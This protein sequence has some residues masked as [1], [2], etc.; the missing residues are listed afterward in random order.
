MGD[1]KEHAG[2]VYRLLMPTYLRGVMKDKGEVEQGVEVSG[3]DFVLVRLPVLT[4]GD[5]TGAVKVAE[6][7]ET[8][9]SITRADLAAFL[10]EQL[11]SD[12]HLGR[13]VTI[14]NG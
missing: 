8:A 3:L 10:V 6:A 7:D 5:S 14:T 12:A 2:F 1:S 4:D 13:A 9:G 11:T